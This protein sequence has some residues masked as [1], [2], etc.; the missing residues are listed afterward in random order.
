MPIKDTSIAWKTKVDFIDARNMFGMLNGTG[1]GTGGPVS[2]AHSVSASELTD[3][4][5]GANGDEFYHFYR[6]PWDM[7][8]G[9]NFRWRVIYS[10]SSTDADTP[11]WTFDY[12]GIAEGE[13][14][15]D[16]T[17][18][19]ATTSTQTVSTTANALG[20]T[21]WVTTN[22]TSYITS[23]DHAILMRWT[24]TSLGGASA[25]EIEL[26]GFEI[27][28][29]INATASDGRRHTTEFEPVG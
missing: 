25:D 23:T 12:M 14:V 13:A 3:V 27:Q 10:H 29:T 2:A 6:I 1:Q 19:E 16:I 7:D 28:Y 4:L 18:H 9:K 22:S 17:S 15:A 24:S 11:V 5:V 26:F 20:L 8:L 21:D